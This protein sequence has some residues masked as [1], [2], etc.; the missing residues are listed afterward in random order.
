MKYNKSMFLTIP[1][2]NKLLHVL[3]YKVSYKICQPVDGQI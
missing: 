1:N 2:A 3:E